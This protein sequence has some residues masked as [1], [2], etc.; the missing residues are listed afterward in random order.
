[1]R[2]SVIFQDTQENIEIQ[3]IDFESFLKTLKSTFRIANPEL[4][5]KVYYHDDE[6]EK[7]SI[8]SSFDLETVIEFFK[9]QPEE[10]HLIQIEQVNLDDCSIDLET[11]LQKKKNL[12]ISYEKEKKVRQLID[13]KITHEANSRDQSNENLTNIIENPIRSGMLIDIE[14]SIPNVSKEPQKE[15]SKEEPNPDEMEAKIKQLIDKQIDLHKSRI[16]ESVI[17]SIRNQENIPI[18][19]SQARELIENPNFNL[20]HKGFK[21]NRCNCL[22]IQGIMYMCIVCY[23]YNFCEKCEQTYGKSHGHPLVRVSKQLNKDEQTF[24]NQK[25]M[26][27]NLSL[28]KNLIGKNLIQ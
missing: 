17:G 13:K 8:E 6:N 19:E 11:I 28:N 21:C 3:H 25:R 27:F 5:L 4:K 12:E 16:I 18:E 1:M 10:K 26:Y 22:P 20:K 14:K 23:E 15:E 24:V 9:S 7:I 2:I